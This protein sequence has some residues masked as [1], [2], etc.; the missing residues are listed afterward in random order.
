VEF[1]RQLIA[2]EQDAQSA[3]TVLVGGLPGLG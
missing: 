2:L 3:I 1:D